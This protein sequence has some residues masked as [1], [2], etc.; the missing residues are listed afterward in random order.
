MIEEL[1][2][3]ASKKYDIEV[4]M[5]GLKKFGEVTSSSMCTDYQSR[6]LNI[7]YLVLRC[8]LLGK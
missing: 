2:A 4:Y 6:R 8:L 3:S 5:P 7:R 1:G